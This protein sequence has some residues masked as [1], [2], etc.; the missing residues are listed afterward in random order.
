MLIADWVSVNK[1]TKETTCY[2]NIKLELLRDILRNVL[3]NIRGVSL[4]KYKLCISYTY[5]IKSKHLL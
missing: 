2:I 4:N 3:K 5:L 1:K